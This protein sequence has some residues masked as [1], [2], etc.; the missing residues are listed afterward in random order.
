MEL[1]VLVVPECP[2]AAPL[3]ERLALALQ[4]RDDVT[5]TWREV[6]DPEQAERLGMH[7]SPT[8]LVDGADPFAR[9]GQEPSLSCRVGGLPSV[10]RLREVV[11]GADPA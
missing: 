11:A 4:G 8:L 9:P 1:T 6:A 3:G 5:V 10:E 7:G 2:H